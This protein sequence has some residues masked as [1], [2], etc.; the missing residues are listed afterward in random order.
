MVNH[1]R[2]NI[3]LWHEGVRF[4]VDCNVISYKIYWA[5]LQSE[6]NGDG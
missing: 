1:N 5:A 4:F 6:E 2:L 3:D